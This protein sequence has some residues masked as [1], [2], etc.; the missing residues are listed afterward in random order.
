MELDWQEEAAAFGDMGFIPPHLQEQAD[1]V[2]AQHAA[3][4]AHWD[5]IHQEEADLFH[6]A[7]QQ[8]ENALALAQQE[9][10]QAF[11]DQQ[12][13][14]LQIPYEARDDYQNAVINVVHDEDVWAFR[15]EIMEPDQNTY[16]HAGAPGIIVVEAKI[17][18]GNQHRVVNNIGAW[19][20]GT[21]NQAFQ[22]ARRR[23]NM[24]IEGADQ[25]WLEQGEQP[26]DLDPHYTIRPVHGAHAQWVP[27]N[28][29]EMGINQNNRV[30]VHIA[31]APF[32]EFE[33][34]DVLEHHEIASWNVRIQVGNN[35]ETC[36]RL[37]IG[38]KER[39]FDLHQRNTNVRIQLLQQLANVS[40]TYRFNFEQPLGWTAP[41]VDARYV[42]FVQKIVFGNGLDEIQHGVL[43]E[44]EMDVGGNLGEEIEAIDEVQPALGIR[45]R[46]RPRGAGIIE[47]IV[48]QEGRGAIHGT[49]RGRGR[50]RALGRVGAYTSESFYAKCKRNMRIKRELGD[51]FSMSKACIATPMFEEGYCFPMAF[52]RAQCRQLEHRAREDGGFSYD[53]SN[54][55]ED[56]KLSMETEDELTECPAPES[57][58]SFFKDHTITLFDNTKH[59]NRRIGSNGVTIYKNEL[60][61]LSE[62]ELRMW[63]WSAKML[64]GYVCEQFGEAVDAHD[65]GACLQAYSYV[66]GCHISLFKTECRGSRYLTEKCQWE[67]VPQYE[68]FVNLIHQGIHVHAISSIRDYL[69]SDTNANRTS[70]HTYC[71]YCNKL[72]YRNR[73][74]IGEE[75]TV[76]YKH[77]SMCSV[78][79]WGQPVDL[80]KVH[81]EEL[82]RSENRA[83]TEPPQYLKYARYC[84]S[85]K[86]I[87]SS[88]DDH[89]ACTCIYPNW[90]SPQSLVTCRM[91]KDRTPRCFYN[92]HICYMRAKKKMD[93]IDNAKLFVWDIEAEQDECE[94]F[95]DRVDGEDGHISSKVK[96]HQCNLIIVKAMYDEREWVFNT[97]GEFV[98]YIMSHEQ[99]EGAVFWAH[100]SGGY[101]CQ[102]L[103]RYLEDNALNHE[104][105]PRPMS[106]HRYLD[107][108]INHKGDGYDIHFKDFMML[109]PQSL[110]KVG[111]GFGLNIVKGDFP[112]NFSRA[113]H[114]NYEGPV[115]DPEDEIND[116]YGFKKYKDEEE[117]KEAKKFWKDQQEIYC[118]CYGIACQ[119]TKQKWNYR[120]ELIKY[121][122]LDV[123]ILKQALVKYRAEIM[124]LQGASVNWNMPTQL[125]PFNYVTQAQIALSLFTRGWVE[126]K[127]MITQEKIRPSFRSEQIDWMEDLMEK[128][129]GLYIQHAGNSIKEYYALDSEQ[130]VDGYCATTCTVYEY[131][132]C[133]WDGC[134][135][136]HQVEINAQ[137]IHPIRQVSWKII[138]DHTQ[139]RL[140]QLRKR[141]RVIL[142][143]KHENQIEGQVIPTREA[144]KLMKM[145]D[146]FYGGR[147]EVFAAYC[148]PEKLDNTILKHV[149]V[150]SLYP[151]ICSF[152]DMPIGVPTIYF[153]KKCDLRRLHPNH[154]DRYFGFARVKVKPNK[155]DFIG[156]LPQRV[157]EEGK[158]EKLEYNLYDK[159]GCWHTELIYLAM[160]HGYEIEEIYEVWDWPPSQRSNTLMRGYMECFMRRKQQSEGWWKLG[161]EILVRHGITS[162]AQL[163]VHPEL[164]TNE[165]CDE[166]CDY[167]FE[168]NGGM[169]RLNKNEVGLNPVKRTIAK[170]FLNSLWGKLGQR[171]PK[172]QE[173]FIYG[174]QQYLEIRS[175]AAIDQ[176]KLSF[177]HVNG[178]TFKVRYEL[179]DN[180]VESN[181]FLNV[182][183]AA[184]VTAHAQVHLM[185]QMFIWGPENILYCD[186]DSIMGLRKKDAPTLE[187][188][189]LGNWADEH[190]KE[191]VTRFWALAPKSYMMKLEGIRDHKVHYDLKCKGI[192]A[193]EENKDKINN[194][195]IHRLIEG[196]FLRNPVPPLVAKAM[197]IHPNCTN[198][199]VG[200]GVMCTRES[201]KKVEVVYSKRDLLMNNNPNIIS[202]DE[203]GIVRTVPKGYEGNIGN[204]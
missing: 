196:T 18:N 72:D 204:V 26:H 143:W 20:M 27:L 12:H 160:E 180:L 135:V 7:F 181:P 66:F 103:I 167:I 51:F 194:N 139:N 158:S 44:A 105:I 90:T 202:L 68:Y 183:I 187:K 10:L 176:E 29:S 81:L 130:F 47:R 13:Q 113:V 38:L 102:F 156:I 87:D 8:Q 136:C 151:Y 23:Y 142:R 89:E 124:D 94:E 188:P 117:L 16:I 64:H 84:Q 65:L 6:D 95:P 114:R 56:F 153:D 121:C 149:D 177:R 39:N 195:T 179:K 93:P 148:N 88:L 28:A 48:Q 3:E 112:H 189:G 32:V 127:V 175:N 34:D 30:Q 178:D 63:E 170:L 192:K 145:R 184:S 59:K 100:N 106:L 49:P 77:Q 115:P 116:W 74:S 110:R 75:G 35:T 33:G 101:D 9:E 40:L 125:D 169:A 137:L 162:E 60:T 203:M 91:C 166:I 119:C 79:D 134:P 1:E 141:Y 21:Y 80:S 165:L 168:L 5:A 99:F 96:V 159:I 197:T 37:Y 2:A 11:L 171:A 4:V 152:K 58:Y 61:E 174:Q 69:R 154:P 164:L 138:H 109:V 201:D 155:Q 55:Q 53:I 108:I 25:Q 198:P 70:V 86:K 14:P 19:L 140:N 57:Q 172:E 82:R 126:Q 62:E 98:R 104:A 200:Y 128:Q 17:V 73:R 186:T 147:T 54:I 161:D 24:Y 131:L 118:T 67:Q 163:A 132:D 193:T 185:K 71:D 76:G 191:N 190:K 157:G 50:R 83:L 173:M 129:P 97:I 107:V 31:G 111:E 42:L 144:S 36:R 120:S 133:Y 122:K 85:C 41:W 199:M 43:G 146:C 78:T 46:L 22:M 150:C 45:G 15:Y 92:D 123:E 182:Y 52:M